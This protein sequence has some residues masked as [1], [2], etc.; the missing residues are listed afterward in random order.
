MYYNVYNYG[1]ILLKSLY[2]Q[3][4]MNK[5]IHNVSYNTLLIV[6]QV[7]MHCIC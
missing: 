7:K 2:V 1:N 3:F 4:I 6:A 5:G